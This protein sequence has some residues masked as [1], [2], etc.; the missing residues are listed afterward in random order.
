MASLTDLLL[1]KKEIE[2]INPSTNKPLK[3]VWVRVLGDFDLNRAYKLARIASSKKR[4]ALRDPNT[5][6]Y[7]DEVFAVADLERADKEDIIKTAKTTIFASEAQ[8]VVKREDLPTLDEISVDPD[9]ASLEDLELLDKKQLEIE[10]LYREKLQA[11]IADKTK[12]LEGELKEKSDEEITKMAQYEISNI[13][14]FSVFMNE[15][16]DQK[17]FFGTFRDK[18]CKEREFASIDDVKNLPRVIKDKL[19]EE[20]SSLEMSYEEIKN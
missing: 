12:E 3:M 5:E 16:T 7:Q 2:V 9:A 11:Y 4:E 13:I 20:I 19:S 18:T 8:A 1:Y 14:P 6:D 15:L 10:K 17:I